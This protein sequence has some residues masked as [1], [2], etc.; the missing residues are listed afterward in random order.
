VPI[1][2]DQ[3]I[4]YAAAAYIQ[5]LRAVGADTSMVE[6]DRF[7][8]WLRRRNPRT[9]MHIHY[10]NDVRLFFAWADKPPASITRRD[11]DAYVAHI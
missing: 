6:I 5:A 11:V 9:S 3:G 1:R 2:S 7:H 10:T 8:K 4:Q